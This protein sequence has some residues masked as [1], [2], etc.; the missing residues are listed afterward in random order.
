M[1]TKKILTYLNFSLNE[2]LLIDE[3]EISM[4]Q[5]IDYIASNFML[6]RYSYLRINLKRRQSNTRCE[7]NELAN[8]LSVIELALFDRKKIE[9]KKEHQL[10]LK[11]QKL[12]EDFTKSYSD[13]LR[14]RTEYYLFRV[15][16]HLTNM[17]IAIFQN[18]T[19]INFS[20]H[21][22]QIFFKEINKLHC[23]NFLFLFEQKTKE[24]NPCE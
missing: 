1:K 23:S 9:L 16:E 24:V 3:T 8:M 20:E 2:K 11:K 14:H 15:L 17:H 22:K 10:I 7:V 6:M 21:K 19:M 18:G 13:F 12:I 5:A 4:M